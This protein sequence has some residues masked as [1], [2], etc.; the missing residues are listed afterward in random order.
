MIL[1]SEDYFGR[2]SHREKPSEDVVANAD[3]LIDAING[4]YAH[5]GWDDASD[6]SSGYRSPDY[7]A[8]QRALWIATNGAQGANTAT[9][10]KHMT[11]QASDQ[12]DDAA[13]SKA[14]YLFDH[15][16]ALKQFGLYMEHPSATKGKWTNWCHLQSV[17]PRSGNRVFFP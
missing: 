5:C 16:D 6:I 14:K 7:N 10:S 3:V 15:Q 8:S 4:L 17:P 9:R 1:T 12:M 11:G 2:M 13:Q